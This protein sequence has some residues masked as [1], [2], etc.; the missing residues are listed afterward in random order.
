MVERPNMLIGAFIH[1]I[2]NYKIN[3]ECPFGDGHAAEKIMKIL[4]NL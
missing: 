2:N 1:H 3:V 4:K